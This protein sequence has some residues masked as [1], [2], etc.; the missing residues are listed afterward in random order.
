MFLINVVSDPTLNNQQPIFRATGRQGD[1]SSLTAFSWLEP[2]YFKLDDSSFP[3]QSSEILGFW[4][5]IAEHVGHAMTFLVWHPKTNKILPRSTLR[6]AL[7]PHLQN[8]KSNLW[9][10]PDTKSKIDL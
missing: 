5:G 4:V 10:H 2:V 9:K 3:S 6:S 1:I 7:S 8:K